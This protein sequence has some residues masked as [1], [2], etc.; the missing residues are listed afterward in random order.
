MPA[1]T[2]RTRTL[3][4]SILAAALAF[5][6]GAAPARPDDAP[7]PG[8]SERVRG[9]ERHDGLL[10]YY[11]DAQQGRLLLEVARLDAD[12]LYSAGLAGGAGLLEVSLDRGQL[13]DLAVVRFER[14][15][16]RVLL[17][18]RQV[19]HRSGSE[20]RERTRVVEESFPS[21]VLAALPIVAESGE[22]LLVDATDFLLKDTEIAAALKRGKQGDWRQDLGR[23][24]L[25]FERSGAFPRNTEL[26][27][28]LSFAAEDAA[29]PA[30]GVSPDGRT[31]SLRVHHSFLKLPE[32]GYEP[33]A[34]ELRIGFI[35]T[36]YRDHTAA[37]TQPVE[38]QLASRWRLRKKDPAALSEPVEPIVFHLDRGMPEPERSA[39]RA[40]ALWWNRA[41]EAAGFKDAL[42]VRDLPEGASFLDARYSGIEWINRAERAWSIGDFQADPRSGEILHAVAR[43][44]SHR[45]RTT[46]RMWQNMARPADRRACDAADSPEAAWLAAFAAD[47]S[48]LR[49]DTDAVGEEALVLQRLSYLVAHEVG[50]TLGLMH[51][52]A[53]TTFGWGSVMDYL[54]PNVQLRDGRLDLQ[55]AFPKAVGPYD[56]L[57]VRWGYTPDADAAGLDRIVREGY[58]AGN[59]YPLDSDARWAEYDWGPD[60]VAWLRTTQAVRRV[61]LERF[62]PDQLRAGEPL[63]DLQARLNLAYLYHRF[64]I[65]AAQQY[66][67][68]QFLTNAV[69]GDGQTPAAWV[70]DAKQREALDLLLTA[71]R[72]ENLD[73]PERVVSALAATPS[74]LAP[75]R[76][77]FATE[78]GDTWSPLAAARAL[79]SLIVQPL[80]DPERA[81]RLTLRSGPGVLTLDGLA[82]RLVDASWGAPAA[83]SARLGALQR[84]AQRAVLDGLLDLAASPQATPEARGV[85]LVRL[86]LLRTLVAGR[87]EADRTNAHLSLALRELREFLEHPDGRKPRPP[88]AV[89]PGRP[90]GQ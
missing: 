20:D 6:A 63:Y 49:A 23:S 41:F 37:F 89:P 61:I 83:P 75:T 85:A 69:A 2:P 68:G 64:G 60:P 9:L 40:A 30:R 5:L 19:R 43:I 12:F 70:P 78:A 48:S 56:T 21:A 8:V 27:A 15:G 31:L 54:A 35:P 76:E 29:A 90:I 1:R 73:V 3:V 84:V 14:V 18:Q 80:L 42:V 11:W 25:N 39:A 45:R 7:R 13:G 22:L 44:D 24:A 33:R 72:P 57:M 59:V 36:S 50:H 55:D 88:A 81:A 38:R 16:P 17:H 86:E 62:G 26:E 79:A 52:W 34:L 28:T 66:V 82:G 71:L 58:A 77:R 46:S 67:G 51:N 87:L 53:A 65:Q 10:P 4:P 47:A 32:P 74:G